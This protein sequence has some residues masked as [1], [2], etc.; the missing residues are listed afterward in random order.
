LPRS[1][2]AEELRTSDHKTKELKYPVLIKPRQ[3][4]GGWAIKQVGTRGELERLLGE[5]LNDG[6][7]WDRFFV[8][9]KIEGETH[10][11]AMLFREG[12]LRAKVTYRQ[13]R[14]YP[15]TGG[16]A[17]V[18]I[19]IRNEKAEDYLQ[20]LLEDLRWHGVCQADFIADPQTNVPY[21]ID[22]NP[23]FWGSLVQAIASGV[24]FP[25][26]LYKIAVEGDVKA[27]TNFKTGIMTR[28][29]GGDLRAFA[30]LFKHSENKMQFLHRFVFP[31][32]A[33][34]LYDDFSLS[35]PL[36]FLTWGLDVLLRTAKNRSLRPIP[37]DSLEGVWD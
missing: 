1:Y 5:P 29:I 13:L 36:P 19:S 37:H 20:K 3:G 17:T 32:N 14:D 24:D 22:I 26:L 27:V 18:R 25:Y 23:R 8:Q 33:H 34:A 28:W 35:D 15:T 6:F 31:G 16:Q 21:L 2:S 11:V 12:E 7:C 9:E 10:C 30:P 4:G